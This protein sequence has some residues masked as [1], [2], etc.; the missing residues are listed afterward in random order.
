MKILIVTTSSDKFEGENSH[1]TGVWLEEFT[2]PFQEFVESGAELIVASPKGGA[3]PIDPRSAASEAQTAEWKEAM[4]A[5]KSAVKLTEVKAA[6]FDALFLPGGHGPMFDLPENETLARLLREFYETGKIIAAVC[7]GPAGLVGAKLSDGTP[8]VKGKTLTCYTYAEE[9][10]AQL[11]KEVPFI[12]EHRLTELGANFIRGANKADHIERDGQLITGQNPASS[13]SIAQAVVAA[14]NKQLQPH[15]E[16]TPREIAAS[17]IIA[18]FPA[19][20]F[21]ENITID[22]NDFLFVTSYEEGIVYRVDAA[23]GSRTEFAKIDGNAAG[24]AFEPNGNL[25]VAGSN[26]KTQTVYRIKRDGAVENLI[27]LADAV[28]LNGMT[29]LTGNRYLV[30]DSYK[31]AIWEIDVETKTARIWLENERLAH[32]KDSF[33]PVPMFPGANGMK[34][35][36]NA[37]YVSSTQQQFLL[38]VPLGA[39]FAPGELEVFLTNLNLDDFAFDRSGNLYGTTHVYNSVVR[40]SPEKVVTVI[41]EA[42]QGLTGSTALSFGRT[43]ENKTAVFVTTNGGISFLPAA[44]AQTGKIVRLEIGAEGYARKN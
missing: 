39:D 2:V 16:R 28:F 6:D 31:A 34:I 7:H 24:I 5:A 33:H 43:D 42:E 26:G 4:A 21:L 18:E 40:I 41:A 38:R 19:T 30:A 17:R 44:Q 20:T 9:V 12:L 23:N 25:L 37:L 13:Q 14:L 1:P 36:D 27:T 15:F 29:H 32:A 8:L 3:M 10:A 22:E 35:Y 11:D